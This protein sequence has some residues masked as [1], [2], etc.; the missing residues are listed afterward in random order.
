MVADTGKYTSLFK[1]ETQPDTATTGLIVFL[2]QHKALIFYLADSVLSLE[3][4]K[5]AKKTP[6]RRGVKSR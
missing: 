3:K 1:R 6:P 2:Q 4:A 5:T